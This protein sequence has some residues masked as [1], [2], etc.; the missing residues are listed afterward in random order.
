MSTKHDLS[1]ER[2][3]FRNNFLTNLSEI[4]SNKIDH[5]FNLFKNIISQITPHFEAIRV[6]LTNMFTIATS[7]ALDFFK[8]IFFSAKDTYGVWIINETDNVVVVTITDSKGRPTRFH[9]APNESKNTKTYDASAVTISAFRER[10]GEPDEAL[11][12]LYEGK[13][14]QKKCSYNP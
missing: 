6:Y 14:K 5:Y 4:F 9:L 11:I 2:S 3:K 12:T 8:A 10:G 7:Y 13:K 1:R